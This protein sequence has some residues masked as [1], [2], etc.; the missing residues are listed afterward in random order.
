M[1]INFKQSVII[2]DCLFKI[3]FISPYFFY[4]KVLFDRGAEQRA[5]VYK[6]AE[7]LLV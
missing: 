5:L 1:P 3:Y 6:A 2:A 4:N 7:G